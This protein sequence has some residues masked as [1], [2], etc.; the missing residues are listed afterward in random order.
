MTLTTHAYTLPY[1][2]FNKKILLFSHTLR[3]PS[4]SH[5]SH[6]IIGGRRQRSAE[7]SPSDTSTLRQFQVSRLTHKKLSNITSDFVDSFKRYKLRFAMNLDTI[8]LF[9]K[10]DT[11]WTL[12]YSLHCMISIMVESD[13]DVDQQLEYYKS[14]S[15]INKLNS[16]SPR[17]SGWISPQT[18]LMELH[19][20]SK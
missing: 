3:R 18:F 6:N 14:L 2:G 9:C 16:M 8:W 15:N 19:T 13:T 4:A 5:I 7:N 10:L 17:Y 1:I 20:L 12:C 11:H